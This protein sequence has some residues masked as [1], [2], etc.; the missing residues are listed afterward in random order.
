MATK[1]ITDLTSLS[2]ADAASSDVLPIV[3][4]DADVTKKITLTSIKSGSFSG[5]FQGGGSGL[6]GVVSASYAITASY[7]QN[8][9]GSSFTAAGISG[10]WQ[11]ATGSMSVLSAS[12]ATTASYVLNAVSA[13]Y[14]ASA[15]YEITKE[16]SSSYADVAG[17]LTEQPSISVTNITASGDISAS[18]VSSISTHTFESNGVHVASLY[19][20]FSGNIL[21]IGNNNSFKFQNK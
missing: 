8:A 19:S 12:Y 1:K 7:A 14:A 17:G 2:A 9:G 3:D 21:Q 4:I 6:T 11:G 5:S 18:S 15:S 20:G 13:S 10:S 16:V